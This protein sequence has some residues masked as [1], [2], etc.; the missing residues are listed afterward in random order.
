MPVRRGHVAPQ[1]TF[2][3][4][5]IRKFDGQSKSAFLFLV[6]I[7]FMAFIGTLARMDHILFFFLCGFHC[8]YQPVLIPMTLGYFFH[9]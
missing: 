9:L 8:H 7:G 2:I 3:D 5:I 6:E 1:N 4:T